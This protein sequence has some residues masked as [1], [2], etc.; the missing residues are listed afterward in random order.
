[1]T[2]LLACALALAALAGC[3]TSAP[4]AGCRTW[5]QQA[6]TPHLGAVSVLSPD[7]ARIIGVQEVSTS[8][9]ATGMAAVQ[10]TVYNCSDTDV[11]LLMR[12]RFSGDRG[13]TENPSAWRT[14]HLAP[15]AA[16][17]YGESALSAQS[18]RVAVDIADANRAQQQFAP[19]QPVPAARR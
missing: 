10:T 6:G 12:S 5:E 2:K 9:T 15:R 8:R 16:F 7:L 3:T 18:G 19:G 1:M 13:Q 14:V 17:T 11:V 4:S